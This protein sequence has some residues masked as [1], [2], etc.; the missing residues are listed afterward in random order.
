[1]NRSEALAYLDSHIGWGMEPGLERISAF[2]DLMG[3][4][5][6]SYPIIHVA[7]T[8]GKTSVSRMA[9]MIL[10]AHGLTTG[11][12][13][14]PHLERF[15]ER[16]SVNGRPATEEEMIQAVVDVK[17]FADIFEATDHV[18]YF[19]LV[20]ALAFA[21]F[22]DLAVNVAVVEVGLGG[23]LDATNACQA[24]VA[25][26]T[27]IGLDHTEMLGETLEEIAVEKLAIL[28][29]EAALVI[30]DLSEDLRKLARRTA[31]E[32]GARVVEFGKDY[33]IEGA[34]PGEGGWRV[35]L[36]GVHA[37]YEDLFLPLRG[38]H[39]VS[40]LAVAV[41]AVE[42]LVERRLDVEAVRTGLS[43]VQSRGRMEVVGSDPIVL[44]DGAHNPEGFAALGRALAEEYRAQRW[45]L[46]TGVMADKKLEDMF[47]HLS[48]VV[49]AVVATAIDSERATPARELAARLRE[50]MPGPVEWSPGP[51]EALTRA[52]QLA[53]PEG[54]VLVTGSL[55]LV[56][57]IRS[58]ILG[59]GGWTDRNER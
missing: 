26:V 24:E 48:P 32:R 19:E 49:D 45:V 28:K 41:A 38:R 40:N 9:T 15:E 54:A 31:A 25:V 5:E 11:T 8:N 36:A 39:Q 3:N 23:R 17:A 13:T 56:G 50:L 21:W 4:P 35:D 18:T 55:Y 22:A 46:L 52:R 42:T 34:A 59:D 12:Y 2:L 44:I 47:P 1:M 30:G 58:L 53:G 27:S 20:T 6:R 43:V 7:G 10:V 33:R 14:S 29:P 37:T 16:I 51:A 57:V